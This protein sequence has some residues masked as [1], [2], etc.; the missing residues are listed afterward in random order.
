MNI[1]KTLIN[2]GEMT[3]FKIIHNGNYSFIENFYYGDGEINGNGKGDG[4]GLGD[5]YIS[6]VCTGD[7]EGYGEVYGDGEG[8][9]YGSDEIRFGQ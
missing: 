7:G 5:G 1:L 3:I 8:D 2:S 4:S 9:G 6:V